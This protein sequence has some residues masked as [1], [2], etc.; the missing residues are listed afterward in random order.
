MELRSREERLLLQM[1]PE[2]GVIRALPHA[3]SG[4]ISRL[5]DACG[6]GDLIDS[7]VH[8]SSSIFRIEQRAWLETINRGLGV[9][10]EPRPRAIV[11]STDWLTDCSETWESSVLLL[12]ETLPWLGPTAAFFPIP[13]PEHGKFVAGRVCPLSAERTSVRFSNPCPS[14]RTRTSF[15]CP[16][17]SCSC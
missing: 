2:A 3:H 6:K 11:P 5:L 12:F 8:S 13:R 10:D 1:K 7:H 9:D 17:N 15:C 16:H 4:H 14:R